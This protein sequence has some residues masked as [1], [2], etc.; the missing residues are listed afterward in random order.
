MGDKK[1]M[2]QVTLEKVN[3]NVEMLKKVVFQIQEYIED[4]FLTHEEEANLMEAR[5]ELENGETISLEDLEK[6]LNEN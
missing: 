2:E 4:S 3:E 1:R 5:K 6:E